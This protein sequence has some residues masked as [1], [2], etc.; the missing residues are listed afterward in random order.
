MNLIQLPL[1]EGEVIVSYQIYR[2]ETKKPRRWMFW[3]KEHIKFNCA[4]LTN[5][6]RFF[7]VDPDNLT[8]EEKAN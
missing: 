6:N 3:Q 1:V 5:A 2:V 4:V 7:I 8:V